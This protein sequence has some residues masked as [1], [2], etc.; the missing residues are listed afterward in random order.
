[1]TISQEYI[2]IQLTAAVVLGTFVSLAYYSIVRDE[3]KR[4][5]QQKKTE[6][7]TI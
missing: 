1:M 4:R 2:I 5:D 7:T 3:R 6:S